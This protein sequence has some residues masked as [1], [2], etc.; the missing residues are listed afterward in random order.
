MEIFG[1]ELSKS[2]SNGYDP[3]VDATVA[4]SFSSAAY[5]FGHSLVQSK[6]DRYDKHHNLI[7]NSKSIEKKKAAVNCIL[8]KF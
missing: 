4:N 6:F 3:L 8:F 5:R 7:S 1:I 2:Y